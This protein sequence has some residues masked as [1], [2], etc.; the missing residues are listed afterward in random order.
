MKFRNLIAAAAIAALPFSATAATLVVPAAG[1][2]AGANASQWQSELT[3]HNAAPR[4][5]TLSITFHQGTTVLG[6]VAIELQARQTLS[7]EDIVHTKFGLDSGTGALVIETNDRQARGLAVTSRTFNTSAR[8]EFG[9]DI[10]SVDAAAALGAGDIG[11]LAGPSSVDGTRFNFGVY[12]TE[13]ASIDWQLVRANGTIAATKNVVYGAGTHAQYNSGIETLL[14]AT[15]QANDTVYGR[16]NS[17][18]AV[19]YGS[20]INSTGDPTFVPGVR[21]REDILIQ[22][23]GVD[24]DENGTIDIVDHNGDHVLDTPVTIFRSLFPNYFKVIARG[25]FDEPVTLEIVSAPSYAKFLDTEGTLVVI[26]GGSETAVTTGQIVLK[27]T[28]ET[29]TQEII[30]PL[31]FK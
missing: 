21:T 19:F 5:T 31:T 6:P 25:E 28:S 15:P 13:T 14:G 26:A 12:V 8:G 10:P 11:A 16:V 7:I 1:T 22:F 3:L 17:G 30:I 4:A 18:R 9:Q 2:G 29:S 24:L 20:T 23:T 27:A